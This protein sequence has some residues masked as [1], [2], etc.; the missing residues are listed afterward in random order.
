[1][2]IY[3]LVKKG[4]SYILNEGFYIVIIILVILGSIHFMSKVDWSTKDTSHFGVIG[5]GNI[6]ERID[7]IFEDGDG[8][9][10]NRTKED[11]LVIKPN[12]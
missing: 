5:E 6:T 8:N 4:I 9:K 1:M 12:W 2:D 11:L 7:I 10:T 3:D